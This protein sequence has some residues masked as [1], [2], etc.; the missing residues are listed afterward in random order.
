MIE[1]AQR[2]RG[3]LKRLDLTSFVKTTGGKGLHVHV[4]IAPLYDCENCKAF[5][6]S[7]CTQLE[8]E[9]PKAFTTNLLKKKR[10]GKIFLDYLR[11]GFGATSIAPYS[12]RSKQHPTVAVP[13]SWRELESTENAQGFDIH[14]VLERLATQKKDPWDGYTKLQQKISILKPIK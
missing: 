6:K 11:N 8:T 2:I 13:I 10:R 5:A 14:T 1:T 4:P 3:M 9:D 12:L 7:V